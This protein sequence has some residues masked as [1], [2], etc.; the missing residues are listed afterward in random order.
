MKKV[1]IT[2]SAGFIGFSLARHLLDRGDIVI[3]IDNHNDY[4]DLALKSA[5]ANLLL[6]H[7]NYQHFKLDLVDHDGLDQIF[8]KQRPTHVVNLAAQ[9]GVRYS[10]ENPKAYID[11]NIVGFSNIL[12]S[13][14][15]HNIEHFVYASSSSVYG[16]NATLPFSELQSVQHP[17]SLYAASK[18]A[19]ELIAH[20]Y[21]HL[22]KLPTTGLRFFTVYG[23]WGRPDMVMYKFT[24]AILDGRPIDV[25]NNGNHQRGF[26]YIDDIV[27]GVVSTIDSTAMPNI[28][29][30]PMSP[31]SE[32]SNAPWRIYNLGNHTSIDLLEL[33]SILEEELKLKAIKNFLPMQMGDVPNS[34]ANINIANE[35]INFFPKTNLKDGV[36]SYIE[37]HRA[38]YNT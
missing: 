9:A 16:A 15:H 4:Y 28:N 35:Q 22:Y 27:D 29:W 5:R 14:R 38:F 30:N 24:K 21:S 32:S 11:S 17:L 1:V 8:V 12:E 6:A 3:G 13:S 33:V 20:S 23:P 10:I 25:Y 19:N 34:V 31:S 26:T 36:K 7:K 2:G 37:W 18:K